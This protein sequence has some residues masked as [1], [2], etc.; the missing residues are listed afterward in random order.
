MKNALKL[1]EKNAI[2]LL[3]DDEIKEKLWPTIEEVL[4]NKEL[5]ATLSTNLKQ[6]ARPDAAEKLAH[7]IMEI[8]QIK[9]YVY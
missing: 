6:M 8:A 7:I 4:N 1:K 3:K 9:S 2:I 5:Q